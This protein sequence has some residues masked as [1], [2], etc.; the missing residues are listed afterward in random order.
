M[1]LPRWNASLEL[2]VPEIDADHR[3]LVDLVRELTVLNQGA[4]GR[5]ELWAVLADLENYTQ[6]HFAREE[7]LMEVVG[8]EFAELHHAEHER[9]KL[10]VKNTIEDFLQGRTSVAAILRFLEHWLLN[11][12]AGSDTLLAGAIRRWRET[13][14]NAAR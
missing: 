8:F 6:E 5:E 11:H 4:A 13:R 10:D 12:I 1:S 14:E 2:G 7:Q 9:M 3:H